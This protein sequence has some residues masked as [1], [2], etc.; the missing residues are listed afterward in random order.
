MSYGFVTLNADNFILVS[1]DAPVFEKL[2]LASRAM[3]Y[4]YGLTDKNTYVYIVNSEQY[5]LVFIEPR[6]DLGQICGILSIIQTAANTYL[7]YII[8]T[9]GVPTAVHVFV[10]IDGTTNAGLLPNSF[11]LAIYDAAG[12]LTF[13]TERL[14][15]QVVGLGY[16]SAAQ[17]TPAPAAQTRQLLIS[18]VS[19]PVYAESSVQ[20]REVFVRAFD[21]PTSYTY[22]YCYY[23]TNYVNSSYYDPCCY[24]YYDFSSGKSICTG[25][26]KST[27][28]PVQQYVCET[29]FQTYWTTYYYYADVRR[30]NWSIYRAGIKIT[31]DALQCLDI[32]HKQGYYDTILQYRQYSVSTGSTGLGLQLPQGIIIGTQWFIDNIAVQGE[33]T[34]DNVF[35]Y[36]T[37][38]YY[39]NYAMPYLVAINQLPDDARIQ[40]LKNILGN[41]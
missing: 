8:S 23:V 20:D 9:P 32:L 19:A 38:G 30:T 15:L 40:R 2:S 24:S 13:S 37:N 39:N 29:Q 14:P 5:P 11:G 34:K 36:A 22:N 17:T 41:W 26:T 7:I 16:L 6:Q 12:K 35:P 25:C 21:F 27:S 3:S 28:T 4:E 1:S 18:Y 33:L 10:P 31:N